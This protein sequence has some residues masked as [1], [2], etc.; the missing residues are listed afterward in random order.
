MAAAVVTAAEHAFAFR[1]PLLRRAISEMVPRPARDALHRQ[2]GEILLARGESAARAGRHLLRAAHPGDPASVAGLDA[3]AAQTL[4]SAPQTAADLALRALE[5]PTAPAD[6]GALRRTVAATEALAAAGRL[7]QAARISR[8]MLARPLLRHGGRGPVAVRPVLGPVQLAAG[9]V[10]EAAEQAQFVLARPPSFSDQVRDQALTAHLQALAAERDDLAGPAADAV[11]AVPARHDSRAVAAAR[12][13]RAVLAWDRG[14][15]D[16]GLE[17]LREAAR[18]GTGVSPDARA[19][20]PLLALAAA[21]AD[22]RRAGEAEDIL[23]A[24]D[25]AALHGIPAQAALSIVRAMPTTWPPGGWAPAAADAQAALAVA[26]ALGGHGYAAT[27]HSVLSMIEL[28]RGDLATAAQQVASRPTP[29][30]AVRGHLCAPGNHASA[31]AQIAEAR[32]G[33][34]A[35]PSTASRHLCADLEARPEL[36]DRR[37]PPPR[38]GSLALALAAGDRGLAARAAPRRACPGRRP[39]R[40]PGP[41]RRGG[42]PRPGPGP[43]LTRTAWPRPPPSTPTPGP[44]LPRRKTSACCGP[45][46]ATGTGPSVT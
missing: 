40:D 34:A 23:R 31:Q 30:P 12:L 2:Y 38:P 42:G 27:A 33:Y 10:R 43:P 24:A 41:G 35:V 7:E 6:P 18:H 9:Q 16:D 36:L 8:D 22:L 46:T 13:T 39:S 17:L 37:P 29:G 14:Q 45:A 11:L 44:G 5:P 15:I 21:L 28:R 32:D 25:D 3:A 26:R 20:Q 1:Q 4:R 19:V